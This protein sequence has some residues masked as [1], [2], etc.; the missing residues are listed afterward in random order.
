M[1]HSYLDDH[2]RAGL[3]PA[4][5][6]VQGDPF[7]SSR[8]GPHSLDRF[9]GFALNEFSVCFAPEAYLGFD[10]YGN[11]MPVLTGRFKVPPANSL[12]RLLVRSLV[13]AT[14]QLNTANVSLVADYCL[15]GNGSGKRSVRKQ[16]GLGQ[17][18]V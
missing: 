14:N 3:P 15:E 9:A 17:G 8:I 11:R 10:H 12:H 18:G 7:R 4:S 5:C 6:P 13:K 2:D 16:W 1:E